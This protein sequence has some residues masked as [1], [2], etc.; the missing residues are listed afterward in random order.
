L[1]DW[2]QSGS[3]CLFR[4][5]LVWP[6]S[7]IAKLRASPPVPIVPPCISLQLLNRQIGVVNFAP[8]RAHFLSIYCGAHAAVPTLPSLPAIDVAVTRNP[9]DAAPPGR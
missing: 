3:F 5:V 1:S 7:W 6:A 4:G 8:L 2:R 9:I